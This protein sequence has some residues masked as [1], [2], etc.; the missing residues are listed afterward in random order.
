MA[1]S[2]PGGGIWRVAASGGTPERL[3]AIDAGQTV[4]NPQMLPDG[5]HVLFS[6]TTGAHWDQANI[7]VQSVSTGQRQAVVD[8]GIDGRYLASGHLVFGRDGVIH[9]VR[10]DPSRQRVIGPPVP[11]LAGVSQQ[12]SGGAWG[13]FDYAVSDEGSLAY[14]PAEA[15]ASR[16]ALIVVDRAGQQEALAS[17]PRAYQYPR[18][19]PD[20]QRV[21]LDLRDQLNDVWQWDVGRSTLTRLTINRR[22]G[23][24]AIWTHDG[25]AVLFGPDVDGVINLYKQSTSGGDPQR[26]TTSPNTQFVGDTTPDGKRLIFEEVHPANGFDLRAV[27]VDE[28]RPPEDLLATRFNEH[29]PDV[30]PDGAW[31]AYQ[32]DESGRYEVY[33]RPFPR[34]NE[35]RW[36]VSPNGGTRPL[37][38]LDGRELFFL[39]QN[40]RMNVVSVA[41][42]RT[43]TFGRPQVLF[44]TA[45]FG[46]QGQ[47]RNFDLAPDGKRF[48]M[49]KNLPP[50]A[51]VPSIVLIQHWFE[52][53]GAKVH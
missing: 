8:K 53:L 52:E 19:S 2:G 18:L 45:Q 29:N 49:V 32:S 1:P 10:F 15:A 22:A 34:V 30:S 47:Q 28:P 16:R 23:G 14:V 26:L 50:P 25:R 4:I 40:R 21:A 35:G 24:P 3:I 51:D 27:G 46:L 7:F 9:A 41:G 33:V 5:D 6:L 38:S 44:D 31:I 48:L 39:D 11:V 13:G 37:W 42:A 20:G 43:L 12:T 36:Q 17:E